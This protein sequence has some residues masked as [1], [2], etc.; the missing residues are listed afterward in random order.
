MPSYKVHLLGGAITYLLLYTCNSFFVF[1]PA[2][3]L[4]EHLLFLSITL[5]GSI[6]PDID[7]ASKMQQAFFRAAVFIAP[8]ALFYNMT[9]FVIFSCITITLLVIPHRTLTHRV[10]FLVGAP[11]A[12]TLIIIHHHP[13]LR[14]HA[15][16]GCLL[17]SAGAFS[18][19]L[20]DFGPKRLFKRTF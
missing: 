19:V 8:L 9:F 16:I 6:F 10:W 15:T 4:F 18:H 14:T 7:I 17:F 12:L 13:S 2:P 20:L 11:W 1:Y 3:L 5:L